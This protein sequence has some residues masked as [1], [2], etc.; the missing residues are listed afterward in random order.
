MP[1]KKGVIEATGVATPIGKGK[2][3]KIKQKVVKKSEVEGNAE[4]TEAGHGTKRRKTA[5]ARKQLVISKGLE[6]VDPSAIG[7]EVSHPPIPKIG[8]KTKV[9]SSILQ[10]PV[11]SLKGT[12]SVVVTSLAQGSSGSLNIIPRSPQRPS[13][14]THSRQKTIEEPW[15]EE[16][17]TTEEVH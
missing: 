1:I 12:S 10:I 6:E 4:G 5:S 13:G 15:A 3:K 9:E 2:E 16:V 11:G 14:H 8:V 7:K 17:T